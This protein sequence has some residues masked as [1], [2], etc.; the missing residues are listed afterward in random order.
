MCAAVPTTPVVVTVA[1]RILVAES[2]FAVPLPLAVLALGGTSCAP[3]SVATKAAFSSSL[4]P[5]DPNAATM[6]NASSHISTD[7]PF[8]D[9]MRCLQ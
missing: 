6:K 5:Q 3:V 1:V 7:R 9:F 2:K 8:N 4:P